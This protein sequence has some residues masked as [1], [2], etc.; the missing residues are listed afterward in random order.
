MLTVVPAGL[1][2][3]ACGAPEAVPVAATAARTAAM[4]QPLGVVPVDMGPTPAQEVAARV[5]PRRDRI[6]M[7]AA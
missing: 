6:V 4:T 2:L 7:K 5:T 1:L 3:V